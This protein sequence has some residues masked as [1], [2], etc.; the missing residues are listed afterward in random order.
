MSSHL[1]SKN[2]KIRICKTKFACGSVWV[3][4]LVSDIKGGTQTEVVWEQ[5]AEEDIW[6]NEGW[7]D[8]RVKKTA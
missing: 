1:L 7:G 8:G 2:V 3:W 5:G 4:N 6:T